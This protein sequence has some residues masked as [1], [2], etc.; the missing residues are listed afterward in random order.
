VGLGSDVEL[1]VCAGPAGIM[2]LPSGDGLEGDAAESAVRLESLE[3]V[4]REGKSTFVGEARSDSGSS[5]RVFVGESRE[6]LER[7]AGGRWSRASCSSN[8]AIGVGA[9]SVDG[10][11]CIMVKGYRWRRRRRSQRSPKPALQRMGRCVRR[12]WGES[13]RLTP[14]NN[15]GTNKRASPG[16][17]ETEQFWL[18][19]PDRSPLT[20]PLTCDSAS[21]RLALER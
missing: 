7:A 11:E 18:H 19:N 12:R 9:T 8:W 20:P 1:E 21:T 4:R 6:S 16:G 15:T 2:Q 5:V 14:K 10:C 3:L 13:T 17:E